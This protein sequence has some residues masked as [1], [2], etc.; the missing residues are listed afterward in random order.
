MAF[1]N[2]TPQ[3]PADE[4]MDERGKNDL[5]RQLQDLYYGLSGD[6]FDEP[7][8]ALQTQ[9]VNKFIELTAQTATSPRISI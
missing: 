5:N 4:I 7:D 3:I 6:L 9:R 2:P 8:P 1:E